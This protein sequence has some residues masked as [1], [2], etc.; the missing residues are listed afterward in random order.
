MCV[1]APFSNRHNVIID[2][3]FACFWCWNYAWHEIYSPDTFFPY[4]LYKDAHKRW[5]YEVKRVIALAYNKLIKFSS[6]WRQIIWFFTI[7]AF[8]PGSGSGSLFLDAQYLLNATW[9]TFYSLM[10]YDVIWSVC[11]GTRMWAEWKLNKRR[12]YWRV[13]KV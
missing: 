6:L 7:I 12:K 1:Y 9:R 8:G 2:F 3:G 4:E 5:W 13:D 10:R 11:D